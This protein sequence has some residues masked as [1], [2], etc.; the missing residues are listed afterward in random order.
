[1]TTPRHDGVIV[2]MLT[3]FTDGGGLDEGAAERLVDRLAAHG[4]HVFVLG[5]TGEGASVPAADRRRLVEIARRTARARVRVYAGISANALTE[6]VAAGREYLQAGVDAVVAH[7]PWF[8]P[9]APAEIEAWFARLVREL[10]GPFLLYNIPQVTRHSVPVEVVARLAEQPG[11]VGFKDSENTPGRMDAVLAALGG[12]PDFS[13][14]MGTG[15]LSVE[16]LRRG[17]HGLVPSMANVA[18]APWRRL[19]EGAR[20]EPA[21]E[22]DALQQRMIA[23]AGVLQRGRS[24]GQSL[25]AMKAALHLQGVCAPA[26]LPPLQ[27]L[28]PAAIAALGGELA[29]LGTSD[30]IAS[31]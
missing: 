9:L 27:A 25:A 20:R 21:P 23:L 8:F 4:L 15:S 10:R 24:L 12:R 2:P 28:E 30:W 13:L 19:Y 7:P 5:T 22:A 1:M 3:P 18:P 29:A 31:A 11:V 17:Y 26:M 6:S 16:A 14:L